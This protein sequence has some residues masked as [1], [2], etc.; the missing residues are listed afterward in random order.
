MAEKQKVNDLTQSSKSMGLKDVKKEPVKA[1]NAKKAN[2]I[3]LLT[4]LFKREKIKNEV[5]K[6]QIKA[7]L[8]AMGDPNLI[9]GKAFDRMFNAV[10]HDLFNKP[11]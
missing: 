6:V 10:I 7:D 2:K 1:T 4:D 9:Q 5:M 8:R 3:T 11:I